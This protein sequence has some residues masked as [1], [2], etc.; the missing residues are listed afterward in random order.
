MCNDN[1]YVA[2]RNE[3]TILRH[4]LQ[5]VQQSTC[6]YLCCLHACVR[7]CV[8]VCACVS[9]DPPV[10]PPGCGAEDDMEGSTA[11]VCSCPACAMP[12]AVVSVG[13]ST[14]PLASVFS[15]VLSCPLSLSV[16]GEGGPGMGAARVSWMGA[17]A[18][19][20]SPS[21]SLMRSAKALSSA[22]PRD[23]PATN[24]GQSKHVCNINN[25]NDNK[26]TGIGNRHQVRATQVSFL[27]T[28]KMK[29]M[30]RA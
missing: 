17:P 11:S 30:Y 20:V 5:T 24:S 10:G 6:S 29:I 23:S 19:A 2:A 7:A 16:G 25:K 15:W 8:S 28:G 18:W 9:D 21:G 14:S 12:A 13:W 3:Q 27:Q 1:R 22:C 26:N 4:A